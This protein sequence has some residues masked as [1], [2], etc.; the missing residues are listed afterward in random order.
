MQAAGFPRKPWAVG[1]PSPIPEGSW[2]QNFCPLGSQLMGN[3]GHVSAPA[4]NSRAEEFRPTRLLWAKVPL[5]FTCPI[6]VG[7]VAALL[8]SS[9]HS[10]MWLLIT[11]FPSIKSTWEVT[12]WVPKLPQRTVPPSPKGRQT[13]TISR[14]GHT[15]QGTVPL[16]HL[17]GIKSFLETEADSATHSYFWKPGSHQLP[18]PLSRTTWS[19]LPI[20]ATG[21][22]SL[23]TCRFQPPGS[24]PWCFRTGP[25]GPGWERSL[26]PEVWVAGCH[27]ALSLVWR[28]GD[29]CWEK[30][31]NRLLAE[32]ALLQILQPL[33]HQAKQPEG[34]G[35]TLSSLVFSDTAST[36]PARTHAQPLSSLT[37]NPAV[38]V[39]PFVCQLHPEHKRFPSCCSTHL[40]VRFCVL[41]VHKELNILGM[42]L[43]PHEWLAVG[44]FRALQ[45]LSG[46]QGFHE[47][48]GLCWDHDCIPILSLQPTAVFL[49]VRTQWK[50]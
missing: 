32:L 47:E 8:I 44:A 10:C 6:L 27:R 19:S 2:F 3:D 22:A 23:Q 33:L 13:D 12:S 16:S 5:S 36:R 40:P 39:A 20:S 21:R 28:D 14:Q 38:G 49:C 18:L 4:H 24:G 45:S 43:I 29:Q 41:A 35:D 31:G 50:I 7:F 1:S 15:H 11:E 34:L 25:A 30:P 26:G 48:S 17:P 42:S 9:W 37:I 46:A